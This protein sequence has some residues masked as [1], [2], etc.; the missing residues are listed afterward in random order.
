V[1]DNPLVAQA[2]STTTWFTGLGLVEDAIEVSNGIHD[3]SWVDA[4]LG[5]VGGTLDTL[6]LTIDPLG[7]LMAWGVGWLLEHVKPLKDSLDWLAGNPAE[8][9][10]HATTWQNVSAATT[11][12]HQSLADAIQAETSGWRGASGD[13]YRTHANLQLKVIESIAVA[14]K[15]IS[16][17]VEGAGL[18]IAVVRELV[19]DLIAQFVA[20]LAV[21]LTQVRF[22]PASFADEESLAP[23]I[24]HEY[25]HVRQQRAGEHLH[26]LLRELEDEAY[27]SEIPAL[28]RYR[29]NSS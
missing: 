6:A 15:A 27:E 24:A 25:T 3:R 22:G 16:Y 1:S 5:G 11:E 8:I 10:A 17:A 14:T 18:L 2:Q 9:T 21:R 29:G 13:A 28:E 7:S 19:R 26:R 20:T 4:S 12:T 23:T